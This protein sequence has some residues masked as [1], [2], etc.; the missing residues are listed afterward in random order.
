MGKTKIINGRPTISACAISRLTG[1]HPLTERERCK[2][3]FYGPVAG[4][5]PLAVYVD[6]FEA[7]TGLKVPRPITAQGTWLALFVGV[8]EALPDE[9][10]QRAAVV[11]VF[12]AVDAKYQ[13][14][15]VEGL[16]ACAATNDNT[17]Q[18]T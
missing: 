15:M 14:N 12:R 6:E 2:K 9:S 16:S 8:C 11:E 13:L 17:R 4:E 3:Q 7:R 1:R 18:G 5:R 10:P